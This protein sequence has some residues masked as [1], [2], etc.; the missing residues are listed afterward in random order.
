MVQV[1]VQVKQILAL[2]LNTLELG[3]LLQYLHLKEIMVEDQLFQ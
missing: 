2:N 1:V 3:I